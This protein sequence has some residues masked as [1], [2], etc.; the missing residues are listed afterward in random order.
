MKECIDHPTQNGG[1]ICKV[2]EPDGMRIEIYNGDKLVESVWMT[3]EWDEFPIDKA[4]SLIRKDKIEEILK[5]L[6]DEES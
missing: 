5:F 1:K 6:N 3:S 4:D 2:K